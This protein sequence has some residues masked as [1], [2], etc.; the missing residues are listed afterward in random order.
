MGDARIGRPG[1]GRA[2][3]RSGG[4]LKIGRT[5]CRFLP[6]LPNITCPLDF[7]E[8]KDGKRKSVTRCMFLIWGGE[9]MAQRAPSRCL[10]IVVASEDE[11]Q[12]A[13]L[14]AS[15]EPLALLSFRNSFTTSVKRVSLQYRHSPTTRR[16]RALTVV[17]QPGVKPPSCLATTVVSGTP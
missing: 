3:R 11:R 17:T 6:S 10:Q 1:E 13:G 16:G 5:S 9:K 15:W 2:E 8:M 7:E 12:T 4:D 14:G